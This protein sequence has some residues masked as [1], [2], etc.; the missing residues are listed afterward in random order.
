MI[1]ELCPRNPAEG[2]LAA[3]T[4]IG[5][6]SRADIPCALR[7]GADQVLADSPRSLLSAESRRQL[8]LELWL[9]ARSALLAEEAELARCAQELYTCVKRE[10]G[11]EA[12]WL[13]SALW[14]GGSLA[15]ALRRPMAQRL[16]LFERLP[17]RLR[18]CARLR[19]PEAPTRTLAQATHALAQTYAMER[20]RWTQYQD[21]DQ[22]CAQA[23][24]TFMERYR[25]FVRLL[26]SEGQAPQP[27]ALARF[28][29]EQGEPILAEE[30]P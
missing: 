18:A 29:E 2:L 17:A 28:E 24:A 5:T 8:H 21:A 15:Q 13:L 23:Q 3:R 7:H 1:T 25:C 6:L 19:C 14:G 4:L 10:Q 30:A 27:G 16:A 12:A 26:A 22:S 11:P 9:G 20:A